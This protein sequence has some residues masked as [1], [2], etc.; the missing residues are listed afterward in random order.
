MSRNC[1][2][3]S[4]FAAY[5][6]TRRPNSRFA[7]MSATTPGWWPSTSLATIRSAW[8]WFAPPSQYS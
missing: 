4:P 2:I 3:M 6:V 5:Q 8:L 7:R 1:R